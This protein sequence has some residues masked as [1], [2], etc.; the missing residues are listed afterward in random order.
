MDM[1]MTKFLANDKEISSSINRSLLAFFKFST[2][3][4]WLRYFQGFVWVPERNK[5]QIFPNYIRCEIVSWFTEGVQK[6][7]GYSKAFR[8]LSTPPRSELDSSRET[9]FEDL[10]NKWSMRKIDHLHSIVQGEQPI[11]HWK[12]QLWI[13]HVAQLTKRL[14]VWRGHGAGERS[15]RTQGSLTNGR[16]DS[17]GVPAHRH[18]PGAHDSAVGGRPSDGRS[19]T[20]MVPNSRYSSGRPGLLHLRE[21]QGKGGSM[22]QSWLLFVSYHAKDFVVSENASS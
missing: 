17:R 12:S 21:L 8:M 7:F 14:H 16:P 1:K 19:E 22:K 11:S 18:R 20:N 15:R 10:H 6:V 3:F 4:G 13:S 5:I 9:E 2:W